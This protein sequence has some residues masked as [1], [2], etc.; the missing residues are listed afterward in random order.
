MVVAPRGGRW[1]KDNDGK[2][3]ESNIVS[4]EK[5]EEWEDEDSNASGSIDFVN[6]GGNTK[7]EEEETENDTVTEDDDSNSGGASSS[8]SSNVSDEH[9]SLSTMTVLGCPR[10]EGESFGWRVY[11]RESGK[12][13]KLIAHLLEA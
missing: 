12:K 10:V 1:S 8:S 3:D 6:G 11:Q 9:A 5:W 13:S 2:G 7:D 4:R